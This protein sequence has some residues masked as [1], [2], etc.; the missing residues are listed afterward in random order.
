MLRIGR[1]GG[2]EGGFLRIG[3]R[4]GDSRDRDGILRK[5]TLF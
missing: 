1:V 2:R 4:G 5:L 3:R